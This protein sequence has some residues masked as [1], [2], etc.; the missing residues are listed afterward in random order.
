M[1]VVSHQCPYCDGINAVGYL[2]LPAAFNCC[3]C[4]KLITVGLKAGV[5]RDPSYAVPTDV[6]VEMY[7]KYALY[8]KV[9]KYCE[10]H[11]II[12]LE[13]ACPICAKEAK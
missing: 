4:G 8:G 12:Y 11:G 2:T 13:Q 9:P 6:L 5:D 10:K 1:P 7:N 3:H